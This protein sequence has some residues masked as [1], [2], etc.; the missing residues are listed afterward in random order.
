MHGDRCRETTLESVVPRTPPRPVY[1]F[2]C[3]ENGDWYVLT[4]EGCTCPRF[5]QTT[6]VENAKLIVEDGRVNPGHTALSSNNACVPSIWPKLSGLIYGAYLALRPLGTKA[7]GGKGGEA[8]FSTSL[9]P[10]IGG[11]HNTREIKSHAAEKRR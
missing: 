3:S 1:L 8:I 11:L 2:V 7:C 10:L 4:K 5:R 9:P 6:T